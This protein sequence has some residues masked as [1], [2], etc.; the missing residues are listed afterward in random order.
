MITQSE[1]VRS[2][3]LGQTLNLVEGN[4]YKLDQPYRR[5]STW[6]ELN[7]KHGHCGNKVDQRTLRMNRSCWVSVWS[8]SQVWWNHEVFSSCCCWQRSQRWEQ[9][10]LVVSARCVCAVLQPMSSRRVS[11][12]LILLQSQE[13]GEGGAL[14]EGQLNK[15]REQREREEQE[16]DETRSFSPSVPRNLS[17]PINLGPL[18]L[19]AFWV[20]S[21]GDRWKEMS[22]LGWNLKPTSRQRWTGLGERQRA[23]VW[24]WFRSAVWLAGR[25]QK[26][27]QT[28]VLTHGRVFVVCLK[29][30]ESE[31]WE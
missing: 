17:K 4:F 3:S 22:W 19:R 7:V 8:C 1:N 11:S 28:E 23:E 26:E 30:C 5:F 2:Q 9:L 25:H 27:Q 10:R 12:S 20:L 21:F 18:A 6:S 29:E 13:R 24:I 14:G 16:G 31:N 15:Q